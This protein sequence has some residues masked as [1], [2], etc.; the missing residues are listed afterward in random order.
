MKLGFYSFDVAPG[1]N[2]ELLAA[3]AKKRGHEVINPPKQKA[4]GEEDMAAL[5]GCDVVVT[6]LS[7]FE[8]EQ[9]LNIVRHLPDRT[10]WIV[11]EDV[12]DSCLRPLARDYAGKAEAVFM[13]PHS[14][15]VDAH[16]F[17]YRYSLGFGPPPLWGKEY[18]ELMAAKATNLRQKIQKTVIGGEPISIRDNDILVGFVGGKEPDLNNLVLAMLFRALAGWHRAVIGFS[19]HPGE[20]ATKPEEEERFA[21]AFKDRAEMLNNVWHL[22]KNW[23]GV[24]VGAA[25]DVMIYAGGTNASISGAYARIPGVYLDIKEVRERIVA[26]TGKETWFV[27]ELGGCY[28]ATDIDSLSAKLR[29][30]TSDEGKAELRSMQKSAFPIPDDWDTVSKILDYI[31]QYA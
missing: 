15:L 28:K 18:N 14:S 27:P 21:E 11:V 6:G 29:I 19:Q 1:N 16:A 5:L 7:S 10:K 30:A 26:Q 4:V 9:E 22:S 8:T 23:K 2:M 17:G 25:A 3:E 12:P 13:A 31:E 20:K 24:E